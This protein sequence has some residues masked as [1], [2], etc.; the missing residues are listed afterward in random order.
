MIKSV[1]KALSVFASLT[2][3]GGCFA[4]R[5]TNAV[6]RAQDKV[7]HGLEDEI[8]QLNQE[9]YDAQRNKEHEL[10]NLKNLQYK[11]KHKLQEEIARNQATISMTD[12]GL[13]IQFLSQVFFSS[14]QATLT[15]RGKGA[16]DKVLKTLKGI[17]RNLRIE[18]HTDNEPIKRTK[19][20]Y[21]SN[22]ELSSARSLSVLHYFLKKGVDPNM[23][24]LAA[25]GQYRSVASNATKSGRQK[26]RRV[27]IVVIPQYNAK[28]ASTSVQ[29]N[30]SS[31][32]SEAENRKKFSSIK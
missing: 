4:V 6:P 26:N 16:L 12:R 2:M 20:L 9:L 30:S 28:V 23:L 3:L 18:G 5:T 27:E 19:Y 17:N 15:Q 24:S 21:P 1:L 7:I 13:V 29:K 11:L 8:K 10:Q 31:K 14:G 22:W 25:Y 32:S